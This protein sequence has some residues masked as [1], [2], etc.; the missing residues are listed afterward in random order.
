MQFQFILEHLWPT[1]SRKT[2][3]LN[4]PTLRNIPEDERIQVNRRE[5]LRPPNFKYFIFEC[6]IHCQTTNDVRTTSSFTH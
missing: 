2:S 6:N 3:V 1:D 4:Q 5:S